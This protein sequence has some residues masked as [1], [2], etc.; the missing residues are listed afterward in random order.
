MVINRSGIYRSGNDLYVPLFENV[1]FKIHIMAEKGSYVEKMPV[2]AED[3][4]G[5]LDGQN[6]ASSGV[7]KMVTM[8]RDGHNAICRSLAQN[9]PAQTP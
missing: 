5:S 8:I 2:D 9:Q 3:T 7:R 4:G 6:G 1:V